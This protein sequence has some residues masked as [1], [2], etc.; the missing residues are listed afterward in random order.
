MKILRLLLA[1]IGFVF[2]FQSAGEATPWLLEVFDIAVTEALVLGASAF[3]GL[4]LAIVI[5]FLSPYLFQQIVYL[6][7]AIDLKFQRTPMIDIAVSVGGLVAGLILANLLTIPFLRVPLI[8]AYLPVVANVIL[9]YLGLM[10]A[11]KKRDDLTAVIGPRSGT[12]TSKPDSNSA[13]IKVLDTSVIID[14][15]IV[16]ICETG[17]IE[18]TIGIPVFV[19]HEL[20]HIADSEDSQRRNRGRRGLDVL[21]KMQKSLGT[22]VKIFERNFPEIQE[23]DSKLVALAQSLDATVITNDYNL[24]KVCRVHNIPV[25]NINELA[26]AVKPVVLPGEEM[27]VLIIKSGK[28]REQG[29]GYLDDGTMI[30]VEDGRNHINE[31]VKVE[32]TSVLQTAAG[33][34]IFAKMPD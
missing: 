15:R 33:R 27:Q 16:D 31:A 12:R 7:D 9:G 10:I 22:Q 8:G 24:N 32:V 25:L 28:E 2:G 23:V 17:I 6:V 4:I 21:N 34:M 18:G 20:Q 29:I 3:G 13:R 5:Y 14:G 11:W 19:L 30:V 1:V 26:N